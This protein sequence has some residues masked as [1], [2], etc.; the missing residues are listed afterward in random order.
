MVAQV[1]EEK[2]AVVAL[3]VY[4]AAEAHL[5]A[6]VARCA[7]RRSGAYDKD[8]CWFPSLTDARRPRRRETGA[9]RARGPDGVKRGAGR[10]YCLRH[11]R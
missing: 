11:D 8:A 1:D 6:D 3:P 5:A 7:G 2:L 4:P 9:Q 10:R